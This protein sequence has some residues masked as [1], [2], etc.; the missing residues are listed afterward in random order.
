MCC[1]AGEKQSERLSRRKDECQ[2]L[3]DPQDGGED[4]FKKELA[5]C[6]EGRM[7]VSASWI[8]KMVKRMDSRRSL[9]PVHPGGRCR[10]RAGKQLNGLLDLG[11]VEDEEQM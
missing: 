6:Q 3:L 7:S 5:T 9:Q 2:R 8:L 11:E 10:G 4:D 1:L